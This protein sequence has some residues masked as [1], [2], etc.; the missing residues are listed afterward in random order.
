MKHIE[1]GKLVI[2]ILICEFV[3]LIGFYFTFQSIPVW[4]SQLVKPAFTPQSWIFGPVWTALYALMGVAL[5]LVWIKG[6]NKK[7]KPAIYIF[8]VQ[9]FLNFIWSIL[10]FGLKNPLIALVDIVILWVAILATIVFF[11]KIARNAALLLVPYITWVS[12]AIILNYSIVI[13]K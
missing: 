13:L 6:I 7:T 12:L 5:Y 10:F 1:L 3:G 4:Y 2:S 9:L 8:G 11:N